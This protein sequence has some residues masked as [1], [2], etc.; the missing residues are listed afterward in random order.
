[1]TKR[2]VKRGQGADPE[3][4]P[5]GKRKKKKKKPNKPAFLFEGNRVQRASVD[6]SHQRSV[7]TA[8]S[9]IRE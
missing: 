1:M 3:P 8:T 2:R 5:L 9:L 7:A 6:I 4:T